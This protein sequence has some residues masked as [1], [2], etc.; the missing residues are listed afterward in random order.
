MKRG[1]SRGRGREERIQV[2]RQL[3]QTELR[4]RR[5]LERPQKMEG[6]R[7]PTEEL[8]TNLRAPGTADNTTGQDL[9]VYLNQVQLF[10]LIQQQSET[11][12]PSTQQTL[13]R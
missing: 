2:E 6:S 11:K 5:V 4:N 12:C 7:T 9:Q 3:S 13:V 1:R 10:N 8:G